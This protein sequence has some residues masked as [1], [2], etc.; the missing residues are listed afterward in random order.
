MNTRPM[1]IMYFSV[2]LAL[3]IFGPA[4]LRRP[5]SFYPAMH[6]G[7]IADLLTPLVM[8]PLYWILFTSGGRVA[9]GRGASLGF[10]I[11][12]AVWVEGQGMHLAAN[13]IGNLMGEGTDA[14]QGL[15]HFYD[16]VLSHFLW[17]AGMLALSVLLLIRPREGE[18]S[19][20]SVS[21]GQ[22]APAAV[23][24]GLTMF[25]AVDEGAT[26]SMGL[27]AAA[28]ITFGILLL[29]RWRWRRDNLTAFFLVGYAEALVLF[30]GWFAYWG[31]FPE[32]SGLGWI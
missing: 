10:L 3:F 2:C 15:V 14:V 9:P 1:T 5:V 18:S 28:L 29:G 12:A 6:W 4:L 11:P 22:I 21:W 7:D 27:P 16:E 20:S 32:F 23:L 25:V 24:Y 31:Y 19:E 30:A 8:I 26:V 17:H 13:S